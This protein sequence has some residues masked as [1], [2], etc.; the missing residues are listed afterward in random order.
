MIRASE[1]LDS[2]EP[3]AIL[4]TWKFKG[5]FSCWMPDCATRNSANVDKLDVCAGV[6]SICCEFR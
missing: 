2:R 5:I 4:P 3:E 6:R 1:Y